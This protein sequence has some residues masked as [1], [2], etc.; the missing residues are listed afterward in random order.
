VVPLP[1]L[2]A[3]AAVP[4]DVMP[5]ALRHLQAGE[6]LYE[7][8]LFPEREFIFRHALAHEVAYGSLLPARRR[9]L[10]FSDSF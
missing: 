9:A 5:G 6:F 1:L 10:T 8:Q 3:M 2:Q 4:E 7:T